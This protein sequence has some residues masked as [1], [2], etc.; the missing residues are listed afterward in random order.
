MTLSYIRSS[1]C[2]L[3]LRPFLPRYLVRINSMAVLPPPVNR[4]YEKGLN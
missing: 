3:F 1:V 4:I 2:F